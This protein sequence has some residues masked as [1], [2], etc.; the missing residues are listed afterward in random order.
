MSTKRKIATIFGGS[1]F[2]GRHVVKRLAAAGYI[3]KVVTRVPERA[4]FLKTCGA[5]G[6]VVL[7]HCGYND[8]ARLR[9]AIEGADLV[10]N[11]VAILHERRRHKFRRLHV[12]LP[13]QIAEACAKEGV[14]RFVH[15]S[16]LAVDRSTSKY[17]QSKREGEQAVLK[18]YPQAVILRP[19]VM[20]GPEDNFFNMFASLMRIA[21]MMPLIGGGKTKFQPVYVGDVADAVMAALL[22]PALGDIDPRG[23]TYELGG[24]DIVTLRDIYNLLF[25]YT[26]CRRPLV[27]VPFWLAKLKAAFLALMPNPMLT[28][29]QVESLKTDNIVAAG[30]PGL[31]A[32][33]LTPTGMGLILPSYLE[34]YKAGGRFADKKTA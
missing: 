3:V 4:N 29:D 9:E 2:L 30:A 1:G 16:A 23:K 17:A 21:P 31:P 20:F 27:Y 28:P 33:G 7:F 25:L 22:A 15:I 8:T 11:C 14:Q 34:T 5:V 24:P 19:S 26:G 13:Q 12:E 10:V 32:L 18:A 6:Q